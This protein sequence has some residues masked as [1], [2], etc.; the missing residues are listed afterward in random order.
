MV[1]PNPKKTLGGSFDSAL[2]VDIRRDWTQYAPTPSKVMAVADFAV[3][4]WGRRVL[5][6]VN[7][8]KTKNL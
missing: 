4:D 3:M 1:N 7:M 6:M 2:A 5:N 8:V